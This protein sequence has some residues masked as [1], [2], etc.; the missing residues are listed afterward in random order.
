MNKLWLLSRFA[1][2]GNSMP[3]SAAFGWVDSKYG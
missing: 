2:I 3:L 1:D